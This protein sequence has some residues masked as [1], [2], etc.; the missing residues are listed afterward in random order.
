MRTVCVGLIVVVLFMGMSSNVLNLAAFSK[1]P[2]FEEEGY[3][4]RFQRNISLDF[5]TPLSLPSYQPSYPPLVVEDPVYKISRG[6]PYL[7]SFFKENEAALKFE[8]RKAWITYRFVNLDRG[9]IGQRKATARGKSVAFSEVFPGIDVNYTVEPSYVLEEVILYQ[10]QEIT[11]LVQQVEFQGVTPVEKDGGIYFWNGER[12]LFGIPPPVMYEL[13]N[14]DATCTGLHYELDF[15]DNTYYL[16]KI[17]D[18][19][20]MKW[21]M[22]PSRRYP[23]VIDATTESYEDPWENSGLTPYGQY[24]SSL[25]EYV[26]PTTGSLSVIQA[27]FLLKGK[28]LDLAISRVYT[29]PAVFSTECRTVCTEWEDPNPPDYEDGP[30]EY[31]CP[32]VDVGNG[33]HLNFPWIGENYIHFVDGTMYK[34]RSENHVGH[35]FTFVDNV[36]TTASGVQYLFSDGKL[37]TITDIEGNTITFGYSGGRLTTITDTLGRV[38]NFSYNAYNQ[39]TQISYGDYVVTYSYTYGSLTSVTDPLGRV[40][41]YSYNSY[42]NEWLLTRITYPTGGYTNYNYSYFALEGACYPPGQ[43]TPVET[44]FRKYQVTSQAVYTPSLASN[45][46]YSYEGDFD[47]ITG[48]TITFKNEQNIT[49]AVHQI[50]VD[51]NAMI[52]QQVFKDATDTQLC[53][54]DYTY[55]AN[56]E[57]IQEDVYMG[58]TYAYTQKFA[59]DSWGNT[60]YKENGEGEKIYYS[61]ANTDS[62]RIFRDSNGNVPYSTGQFYDC[63]V[64]S[65]IHRFPLGSLLIQD[66]NHLSETYYDYDYENHLVESRILFQWF[67]PTRPEYSDTFDENGQTSFI[68]NVPDFS[69]YATLKVVGLPT[70]HMVTKTETH[71]AEL[72][73]NWM[74]E[75]Y[76]DGDTFYARYFTKEPEPEEGYEPIGPFVH[77][78]GT[79][80]YLSYTTWVEGNFQ[81]VE[82]T[83]EEL[84]DFYPEQVEYNLNGDPWKIIA[85]NLGSGSAFYAIPAGEFVVGNNTLNF[86]E[87]SSWVTKFN[88]YLTLPCDASSIEDISYKYNYDAYGNPVTLI[89]PLNNTTYYGYDSQ[90]HAFLVSITDPLN[91]TTTA[92]YDV[93]RGWLTS[94]TDAK[95]YTASFEYDILG[96]VTKKIF[97]DLSEKEV[98][99]DDQNNKSTIYD[100][101][102]HYAIYYYDGIGRHTKTEWYT[103]PTT[104]LTET[105]TYNYLSK[106]KTY[107][108]TGGNTYLYEY[109]SLGRLTKTFRPDLTFR[110]VQ[111]DDISHIISIIDENQHKIKYHYGWSDHLLWVK[112]YTDS[113]S[114]YLTQYT[115]DLVGNLT[116]VIDANGNTTSCSFES[117]FGATQ[118][119]YPDTTT[120]T[121]S[122]DKLGNL[123]HRTNAHGTTTL[124]YDSVS[125]VTAVEYPD[126]TTVTFEYDANGNRTLMT[127]YAGTTQYTYDNRNRLLSETRTIEGV[128]YTASYQYDAASRIV[129]I[130]YPD[131]TVLTQEY[132]AV[133]RLTNIPGY[134]QFSYNAA[135]LLSTMTFSNNATTTYQYD[136][137]NRPVSI[138]AAKDGTDLLSMGYQYDPVGNITQMNYNRRLPDQSW[139]QSTETFTF[140]WLD[141]LLTAQG[142]YGE[143]TYSFD[144][145]GNRLSQNDAIYAYN[146]MN[147]LLYVDSGQSP[148]DPWWD[149]NYLY[150]REI[151]F[152]TDHDTI[153]Q[154]YTCTITMDTTVAALASGDDVRVVYQTDTEMTELDRIGDIWNNST[155]KISFQIQADIPEDAERGAGTYYVYYDNP[156]AGSPP[157]DPQNVYVF[158]DDFNRPDSPDVGNSWIEDEQTTSVSIYSGQ[159]KMYEAKKRYA[160]AEQTIS[161]DSMEVTCRIRPGS[162]S[163]VEWA[164]SLDLFWNDTNGGNHAQILALD[165]GELSCKVVSNGTADTTSF[166]GVVTVGQYNWVRIRFTSDTFYFD[167]GGTG[168]TPLW[169]NKLTKARPTS[170]SGPF[171]KIILGK[172]MEEGSYTN[173]DLDNNSGFPGVKGYQYIDDLTAKRYISNSPEPFLHQPEMYEGSGSENYTFTYDDMGNMITKSNGTDTWCY[174]YDARNQLIQLEKNQQVIGQY[175]YDGDGRRI[176]KTEWIESL[177][178]YHDIIYVYSGLSVIYE[179][180]LTTDQAAA[181]IYG[182]T[183]RIA[184]KVNGLVDYYH[185]DHLGSTRLI[186]DQSG[187]VVSEV[188]Y[189]PFGESEVT[190]DNDRYLYNGKEKDSSELY[191]YGRR[192]YD[193]HIGRFITRDPRFGQLENPQ[194]L[195]RYVY[196]LNNPLKYI[197]P[198]GKGE[199]M[200]YLYDLNSRKRERDP[201]TWDEMIEGAIGFLKDVQSFLQDV[202]TRWDN[203]PTWQKIVLMSL[204]VGIIASLIVLLAGTPGFQAFAGWFIAMLI[205]SCATTLAII[206]FIISIV[207]TIIAILEAL[208]LKVV[209]RHKIQMNPWGKGSELC[210][211]EEQLYADGTVAIEKWY[212]SNGD[213][214]AEMY[215]DEQGFLVGGYKWI[216]GEYWVWVPNDLEDPSKGGDWVVSDPPPEEE[217]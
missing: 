15:S 23:V 63:T 74:N 172:G 62:E 92:T 149:S 19:E 160:H 109:D 40:T 47:G 169:V 41:S 75:G 66:N 51:T 128:Q 71:S 135:S 3:D 45:T 7:R 83:Y 11:E 101:L 27:D 159:L 22:D 121:Y 106:L 142:E 99:Y 112:E 76:W 130:T 184:K 105:Y 39:L 136:N 192:Y 137:R 152:G 110:E 42:Q 2:D 210:E 18:E 33:W 150:R 153:P 125:Q 65:S 214:V 9:P 201:V 209:N 179:K 34:K 31:E 28:G 139:V 205:K 156:Q 16:R 82:T 131:Q 95:G 129:S 154:G 78:P 123:L 37:L 1:V 102:D 190:G 213:L 36:L 120:E 24:F 216:E 200:G 193:P 162:N 113:Q 171:S 29:T 119:S 165:T 25:D 185:T 21:L 30:Y 43:S 166:S 196:V 182:P 49:K 127:D 204:V 89:D 177:Q 211:V 132:D 141:R 151:T 32:Y 155:T 8:V 203:L 144:P 180:N 178:Q 189:E 140:D 88:W 134:A 170:L 57:E 59:Y 52:S 6:T 217:T 53:K 173:P 197:D 73:V 108:N 146:N 174:T 111:Y 183:G 164:P 20:G 115:Y 212:D 194:T 187:N 97:P 46:L 61:F 181:Y 158:Y 124:T 26:S 147:E 176:K 195:N 64:Q 54:V 138:H 44:E 86:H 186:T 148:D 114:Y 50:S 48:T 60:I 126:Q 93:A 12:F 215:Y 199:N 107:T 188:T 38:V 79:Q 14:P 116:S 103:S 84:E 91:H 13:Q 70:E 69:G 133:N 67:S 143:V 168:S 77:Y 56:K 85:P 208:V 122:Y 207:T 145:V 175:T 72:P 98:V 157:A 87:S 81:Y 161:E 167:Y 5:N 202:V 90:Y 80:G 198:T 4:A 163:G 118:I 117:M 191:Y 100:T 206:S 35:H 104:K 94:M 96:R 68:I 17:I 58:T 10:P 55:S